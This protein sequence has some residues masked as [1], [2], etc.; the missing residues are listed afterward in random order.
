MGPGQ[1]WD[2]LFIWYDVEGYNIEGSDN[3]LDVDVNV[4]SVQNAGFGSLYSGSPYLG[5]A[6]G[7]IPVG[8]TSLTECGEYYIISHDHALQHITAWGVPMSGPITFLRINPPGG[9]Q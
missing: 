4:P 2:G 6:G 3:Y 8:T 7:A 9:C 5:D 1:T